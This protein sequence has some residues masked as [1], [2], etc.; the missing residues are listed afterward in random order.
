MTTDDNL[1][2]RLLGESIIDLLN[3][4][5]T[6]ADVQLR[7]LIGTILHVVASMPCKGCRRVASKGLKKL[8]RG[9]LGMAMQAPG[10]D[11]HIH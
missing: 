4:S 9:G 8:L 5:N 6:D 3:K 2:L 1:D 10:S 11:D 7:A